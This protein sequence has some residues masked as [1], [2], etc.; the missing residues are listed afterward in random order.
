M[1]E[2]AFKGQGDAEKVLVGHKRRIE[3]IDSSVSKLN[4]DANRERADLAKDIEDADK[5]LV[6]ENERLRL[7]TQRRDK[8]AQEGKDTEV[9]EGEIVNSTRRSFDLQQSKA[10]LSERKHRLDEDLAEALREKDKEKKETLEDTE[11]RLR[12]AT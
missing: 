3:D 4:R 7:L 8:L 12:E 9:V 6:Y 1:L 10:S 2:D 5:Q 11:H